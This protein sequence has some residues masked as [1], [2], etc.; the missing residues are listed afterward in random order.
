MRI[1]PARPEDCGRL[2][3]VTFA[4]KGSWGYPSEQTRAWV[5]SLDLSE[6]TLDASE[7]VVAEIDEGIVAW[8]Q[9]LP[10][11]DGVCVLDHL[12]VEPGSMRTGVGTQLFRYAMTRARDLGAT[13]MEWEGEPNAVGFYERMGGRRVR[14]VTSEWGRE[15]PVMAVELG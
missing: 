6:R 12:W 13:A 7:T 5:A 15:L 9:L 3:E 11:A 8:A 14:T 10:P 1:R 4:S 2:R